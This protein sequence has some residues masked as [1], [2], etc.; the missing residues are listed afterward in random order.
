MKTCKQ[1]LIEK[2]VSLFPKWK[3]TCRKC[4]NL[5]AQNYNKKYY[6]LNSEKIKA[7]TKAYA[8]SNIE[9]VK[10]RKH[11][12]YKKNKNHILAKT[13]KWSIV[14]PNKI[15]TIKQKYKQTHKKETNAY[16]KSKRNHDLLYKLKSNL[17][18]RINYACK[19]LN[20]KK[21]KHTV[22]LIG[23]SIQEL[24]Y[25]LEKQFS[26]DM[27]WN[28]YGKGGWDIDHIIPLASAKTKEEIFKLCHYTNL[29]PLWHLDNLRKGAKILGIST[30]EST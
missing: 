20:T 3:N 21:N 19:H 2:D 16:E 12:Y 23:C 9:K 6:A 25:H 5:Y 4:M 14:N 15:K 30:I 8:N 1:C 26:K 28:N 18:N 17:R 10:S 27:S 7:Q 13:K 11:D 24:K 29:Q 22:E